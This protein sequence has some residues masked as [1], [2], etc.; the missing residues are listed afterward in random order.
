[1]SRGPAPFLP[2]P[3]AAGGRHLEHARDD[4]SVRKVSGGIRL[5]EEDLSHRIQ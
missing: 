3:V 1:V 4:L 2:D 5:A